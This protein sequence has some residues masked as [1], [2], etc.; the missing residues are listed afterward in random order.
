MYIGG[1]EIDCYWPEFSLAVELDGRDY[2]SSVQRMETDRHQGRR[3]AQAGD[4]A[5][6]ITDLRFELEPERVFADL[7]RAHPA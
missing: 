6:R 5:L 4:P 7:P 1:W 2:H 3:A